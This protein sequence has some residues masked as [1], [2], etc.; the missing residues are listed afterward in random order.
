MKKKEKN[1]H[2]SMEHDDEEKK[3]RKKVKKKEIA[4]HSPK[5]QKRK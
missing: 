1:A 5:F 3:R 2:T 4:M